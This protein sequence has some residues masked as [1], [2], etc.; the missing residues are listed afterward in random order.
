MYYAEEE[1]AYQVQY[2]RYGMR[3]DRGDRPFSSGYYGGGY[4]AGYPYAAPAIPSYG[5]TAPAA[6]SYG[7]SAPS[8]PADYY[9]GAYP[10]AAQARDSKAHIRLIVPAG[11][12]VWFG[13]AATQQT[14]TVR[15]FDS[16]ELTPGKDYSYEVKV[17]WTEN[18]KEVTRTREV[19]VSAGLSATVDFTRQ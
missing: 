18:G 1:R 14:G 5:A 7:A 6:Y 17:R 12:R 3:P 13:N 10:T 15:D 16:P 9:S 19:A 2:G 4:F 8:A 11:A